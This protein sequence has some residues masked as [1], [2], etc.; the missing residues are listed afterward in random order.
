[1]DRLGLDRTALFQ[2]LR[3]AFAA[4]LAFAVAAAFG[5]P[6]AFWAAMPVWVVA[7]SARGLLLERAFFRVVGTLVGAGAG[8]GILHLGLPPYATLALLAL[9]IALNAGLTHLLRGVH[10]YGTLLAGMTAAVV[11]LPSLLAPANINDVAEARVACTLIG[12]VSVT[13]VTA[14]FTPE[15]RRADFYARVQSLARLAL[16]FAAATID[17]RETL[18]QDEEERRLLEEISD[19]DANAAMISAGS[20]EGYRM[21]R[22]VQSLLAGAI[23][24]MAAARAVSARAS[25]GQA[26]PEGLSDLL[27]ALATAPEDVPALPAWLDDVPPVDRLHTA[28]AQMRTA[29]LALSREPDTAE[30]RSFGQKAAR[31]APHREWAVVLRSGLAAG[32]ASFVATSAGLLSGWSAGE[33]AALGVCIFSMVL[34]SMPAPRVIAPKLM[35]GVLAGVLAATFY[36]FLIQP[37]VAGLPELV[38]S[39]VPFML[40]GGV[41]RVM[42]RTAIAA[43]DFNMCFM[44]ASQAGMPVASAPEILNGSAALVLGAFLVAAAVLLVPDRARL[45]AGKIAGAIQADLRRLLDRTPGQ[46]EDARA[47]WHPHAARLVLRLML[48]IRCAGTAGDAP[49]GLLAALNL[50]HAVLSLHHYASTADERPRAEIAVALATLR[51]FAE[52]PQTTARALRLQ[53]EAIGPTPIGCAIHGAADALIGGERLF[54]FPAKDSRHFFCLQEK[55]D[56]SSFSPIRA[57]MAET[58]AVVAASW[59]AGPI[60]TNSISPSSGR[61][62]SGGSRARSGGLRRTECGATPSPAWAAA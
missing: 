49:T 12:V 16:G 24:L 21:L 58:R 59:G 29:F 27:R 1:M 20:V 31:L 33:L 34:G 35:C 42:K 44:L 4:W 56:R 14:L 46:V 15:G 43:I 37:H 53:A 23:A 13:L 18:A 38:L 10:S 6:N 55:E 60:T 52:H 50:G 32:G 57:R 17:G 41:A 26:P 30:V 47:A 62:S 11:V 39:V 7:Q 2:A 36:R 19:V 22:H 3:L 45:R 54:R 51:G 28:L 9:W 61:F 25:R 48:T 8:F 40:A 5:I